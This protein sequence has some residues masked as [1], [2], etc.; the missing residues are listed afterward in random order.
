MTFLSSTTPIDEA[1]RALDDQ[2]RLGIAHNE[3]KVRIG[4]SH[5]GVSLG[6]DGA[7]VHLPQLM[8]G[9]FE[10]S[11]SEARR[12]LEQGGVKLDG[13]PLG[14]TPLDLDSAE[15]EG[16]VLQVGKRRFAMA[17][18]DKRRQ[19]VAITGRSKERPLNVT[20]QGRR[21]SMKREKSPSIPTSPLASLKVLRRF[22][23]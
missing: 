10:I 2:V 16:R 3:L 23:S 19:R 21:S 6:E 7:S 20:R 22:G 5:G 11:S 12:L 14:A 18:Q 4:A 15:L 13:E 8:A 9:A 17:P 1:V